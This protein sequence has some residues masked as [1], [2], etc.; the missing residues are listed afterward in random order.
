MRKGGYL[1]PVIINVNVHRE[2]G[3]KTE[4][5]M[6][7]TTPQDPLLCEKYVAVGVRDLK[8]KSSPFFLRPH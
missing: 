6:L 5:K 8:K 4:K 7:M 1:K 3:K 2:T